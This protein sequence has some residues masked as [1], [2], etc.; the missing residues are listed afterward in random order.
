MAAAA[1]HGIHHEVEGGGSAMNLDVKHMY[2]A[3]GELVIYRDF[4]ASFPRN[5]VSSIVG[6]SGC[7]KTTLL[8]MMAGTIRPDQ[9]SLDDFE[10]KSISVIFQEPRLLPWKTVQEN[11]VFVLREQFSVHR[12]LAIAGEYLEMV[13][14]S[15][16][17]RYYP[18]QLSGGMKQRVSMARAFAYP[19]EI[20]LMDEPFRALDV[21]LKE[22]LVR[23]FV[24]LWESDKRTVIFVT[25]DID[26]AL[27]LGSVIF[28]FSRAPVQLVE[29]I[30][31]KTSGEDESDLKRKII[32]R[33]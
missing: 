10:N 24:R 26:E 27:Q 8:N 32:D 12:C 5:Q 11:M 17:A 4:S 13:G 2:K 18:A 1:D 9:G 7:G 19:S 22:T 16:F 15:E 23:S 6:P 14:L 28:V 20:I 29:R 21:K 33:L 3:W 25:H 31:R 30:D